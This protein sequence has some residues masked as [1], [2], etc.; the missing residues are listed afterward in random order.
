[1]RTR[2]TVILLLLTVPIVYF[3]SEPGRSEAKAQRAAILPAWRLEEIAADPIVNED[4]EILGTVMAPDGIALAGSYRL[5]DRDWS[6]EPCEVKRQAV[7]DAVNA[8]VNDY[9]ARVV[10]AA[11]RAG[12]KISE[13]KAQAKFFVLLPAWRL[14]EVPTDPIVSE[15]NE[16]LGTVMAPDGV[17]IAGSYR[18]KGRNWSKETPEARR[19]AVL[20]AV[21]AIVNDYNIRAMAAGE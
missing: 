5:K 11:E 9:N 6:K 15:D 10:D 21:N 18:L 20:D 4:N 14:E 2:Y 19:Q 12:A 16:I 7:L 1:M 17:G 8:I 13:W 3:L